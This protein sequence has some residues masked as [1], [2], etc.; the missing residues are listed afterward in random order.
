MSYNK[1]ILMTNLNLIKRTKDG[2]R[3]EKGRGLEGNWFLMSE[4][5]PFFVNRRIL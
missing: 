3:T 1:S 2:E 4:L 5:S